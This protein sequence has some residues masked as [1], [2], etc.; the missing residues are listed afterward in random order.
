[1]FM[2]ALL[3]ICAAVQHLR[4]HGSMSGYKAHIVVQAARDVFPAHSVPAANDNCMSAVQ[5]ED[6]ALASG[7]PSGRRRYAARR[8][9]SASM[10][11]AQRGPA[12]RPG[13]H[14]ARQGWRGRR[15]VN[16]APWPPWLCAQME[17]LCA[18]MIA[19]AMGRP[20][21]EPPAFMA[22]RTP[23]MICGPPTARC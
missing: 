21:P 18:W 17:P 20:S 16:W 5:A 10:P 13:L 15:M 23:V 14:A 4:V 8:A 1:M 7:W 6:A 19:R 22:L 11:M 2:A 9:R 3:F 12:R